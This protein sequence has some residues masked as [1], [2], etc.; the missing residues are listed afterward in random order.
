METFLIKTLQLMLAL[1]LLV[2]VHEFGHYFFSRVFGVKV[3]KF[4]LFFNPWFTLFKY[5][6]KK[7]ATQPGEEEKASWRDTEYGIGWL[8][9]GGYCK[10][11]GMIDESMDKEQMAQPE[12]PWEFRAKP[13]YQRLLIMVGGVLFNF[14][15]A[16]AIYSGIVYT[17]GEKFLPFRN[18][19]EG[20]MYSETAHRIG[21]QDGDIPLFADDNELDYLSGETVLAIV[22]AKQVKVL[23]HQ[24]DTIIIDIPQNFIFDANKDAEDGQSLMAYRLPVVVYDT[25]NG[26]GAKKS[27]M[28]K[29]DKIV[30]VNDIKTPSYDIFKA[31]LDKNKDKTVSL[32][33]I[34]NG[35]ENI[36]DVEIDSDGKIGITLTPITDIYETITIDYSIF[37]SIPRGI[38]MGVEK[39]SGYISQMKYIFTSEGA[40]SL[41]G[42]GALGSIFPETWDWANFWNITAFLSVILAFM[43]ILPIPALDG[44][45]VLF[46]LVEIITRRKPS[47][48]FLEYAQMAGMIFL[49]LLMVYANGNDIYRFFLK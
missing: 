16:I 3:E 27:G 33:Y 14:I 22:D 34:R 17:W 38:E 43:N 36:T 26:M 6:P 48:K 12:K 18:A 11:A 37:K 35:K 1:A 25:Q 46:L 24:S 21:F 32:T 19:S 8:P 2:L 13:A 23:R 5:K 10:I 29:G 45:H 39:L 44:G 4:Y 49:L 7:R 28:E 41:G 20:M 30:A 9:L 15:A 42:F 31:E 47:D 40:K